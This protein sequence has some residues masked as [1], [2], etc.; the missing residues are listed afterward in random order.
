MAALFEESGVDDA[1][2]HNG[3]VHARSRR[4]AAK[5]VGERV[6]PDGKS[7]LLKSK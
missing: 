3:D 4:L 5:A 2:Y 7:I 1:R 6:E